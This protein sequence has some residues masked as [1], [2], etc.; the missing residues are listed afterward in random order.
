MVCC[1]PGLAGAG[2]KSGRSPPLGRRRALRGAC[3]LGTTACGTCR[4]PHGSKAMELPSTNEHR[5][6]SARA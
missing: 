6:Y 2:G 1:R 5:W 4:S 3:G